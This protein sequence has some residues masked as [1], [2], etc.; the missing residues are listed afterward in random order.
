M[1]NQTPETGSPSSKKKRDGKTILI[2]VLAAVLAVALAGIAFL[3]FAYV[4]GDNSGETE[5][6][7]NL[8]TAVVTIMPTNI[9]DATFVPPTPEANDPTAIVTSRAGVNVRTGPGLEYTILG[10]APFGT[11]LEIIGKSQDGTWWVVSIPPSYGGFGW[12]SAEYVN[13]Q[14]AATVPVIPAPP[15][16][17]PVATATAT[18]TPAP[19]MSFNASRTTINAGEKA[20]LSWSV[21]NIVAVYM[22]PVGANFADYPVTGQGSKEVQPY[23][24]TTYELLTFNPNDTTSAERIEITVVNGLTSG[25]WKL[26]SYVA[27]GSGLTSPLPG[28]EVTARFGTDGSLSGSGGCNNYNGG[29]MAFDQTL[30]ISSL[31]SSQA[32][33]A[34][35]EGIMEQEGVFLSLMQ[36]ASR[37]AINAGQLEVF[38]SSGNRILV[39]ING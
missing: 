26:L 9:P 18:A 32:L 39:F 27:P 36:Q 24:T 7:G 2:I 15:T 35:P 13:V 17:T 3:L 14:N 29:F 19:E 33:C 5:D 1:E 4:F 37:M 16:P 30:R 20:T 12:V 23:I 34:E 11:E 22:Y 38:D 25:R 6:G 31:V 28:T 21:E 8:P 10:T